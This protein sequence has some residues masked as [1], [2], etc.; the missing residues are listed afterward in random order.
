MRI[1][2]VLCVTVAAAAFTSSASAASWVGSYRL[3][4]SAEPVAI[5]VELT[6]RAATVALAPGHLGRTTVQATVHGAQVRFTL[7]GGVGFSGE[8]RGRSLHGTVAQGALR[9]TFALT[10]GSSRSLPALGVYRGPAGSSIAL[11]QAAGFP[12]WL[13]ELPSGNIH[14]TGAT[15]TTVG[16]TAGARSG[17]GLLDVAPGRISWHRDGSSTVYRRLAVRQR[18]VRVG[19]IAA[20]LTLPPGRGPFPAVAMVHG[21]GP[22]GREEFQVFAAFCAQLGVAV[23]ADDKRGVGE[24]RGVYPGERA[25]AATIDI[26]ARDAQA[27][28]RY[29]R[30][31]PQVDPK[32]IGLLGD[33]Q[34]GWI[35]ALAAAREPAVRWAVAFAGP[36]VSVDESDL[37]GSLAG[38]GSAPPSEPFPKILAA[39]RAAGPGGFDPAPFLRRLS[40]PVFWVFG[41]DDRNVPT[42]L[43]VERLQQLQA[44]HD[45]SWTLIHSTHSLLELPSGLN[46]DIPRSRGF[47]AGMF[48]RVATWLRSRAIASAPHP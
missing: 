19:A 30:T 43:C 46:A 39:V 29:L 11:V 42:Q 34:A 12:L 16:G 32:R 8:V 44:G 10:P 48:E 27:E 18:E 7:P 33:S 25:T 13:V 41:D 40:I 14:G 26:L 31:I 23:I 22:Q 3:P 20:T 37:W 4:E 17:D 15:L 36:T 5:S 47:G 21:A 6:A 24:S 2:T 35:I 1:S 28:A 38:Q 9:G 45:F